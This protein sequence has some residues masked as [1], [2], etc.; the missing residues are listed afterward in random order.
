MPAEELL[1]AW[2]RKSCGYDERPREAWF[3]CPCQAGVCMRCRWDEHAKCATATRRVKL[4]VPET[5]LVHRDGHATVP[6]L[7]R[8]RPCIWRCPC[9]DQPEPLGQLGL[10][11]LAVAT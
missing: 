8:G 7:Q 10:F 11:D 2:Y 4:V 9:C 1:P 3:L 6:L 5:H